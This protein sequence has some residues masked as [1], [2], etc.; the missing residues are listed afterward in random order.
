MVHIPNGVLSAPVLGTGSTVSA[1]SLSKAP[2]RLGPLLAGVLLA[3]P[4]VGPAHTLQVFAGVDGPMIDGRAYFAGGHPATGVQIRVLDAEGT[5]LT[6]LSPDADGRFRYRSQAPIRQRIVAESPDGHRAEWVIE[7]AELLPAFVSSQGQQRPDA[8]DG[9][10]TAASIRIA[11]IEQAVARQLRPLR[12]EL[13]AAQARANLR[14]VLG[15]LGWL[16]GITGLM[17]W[18]RSRRSAADGAQEVGDR[19]G[20][21]T[22]GGPRAVGSPSE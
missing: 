10:Q 18:W 13:A 12:E 9:P 4:A 15:G 21:P 3:V 20:G 16:L 11:A 8:C 6:V 19:S 1:G 2:R 17:L 7:A 14:D 22:D 5:V